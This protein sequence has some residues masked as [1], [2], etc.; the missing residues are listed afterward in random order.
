MP[1][2]I[3][4]NG[5]PIADFARLADATEFFSNLQY[6]DSNRNLELTGPGL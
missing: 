1:Y 2:T 6:K 5:R 4:E 3:P